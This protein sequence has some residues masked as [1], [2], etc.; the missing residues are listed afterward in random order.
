M[1]DSTEFYV[2]RKNAFGIMEREY[3]AEQQIARMNKRMEKRETRNNTQGNR[4]PYINSIRVKNCPRKRFKKPCMAL[5]A[6]M[7]LRNA[8][9]IEGMGQ[10]F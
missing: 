3:D 8:I 4:P 2:M 7:Q 6:A 1:S 10:N 9:K 5:S